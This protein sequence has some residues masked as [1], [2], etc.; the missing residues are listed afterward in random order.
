MKRIAVTIAV[1]S[2]FVLAILGWARGHAPEQCALKAGLGA[3]GIFILA[4]I[5][6]KVLVEMMASSIA[7]QSISGPRRSDGS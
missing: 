6:G 4:R 7:A 1:A 5:A 2:F 3:M